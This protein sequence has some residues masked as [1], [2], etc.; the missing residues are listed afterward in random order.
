[1]D[2]KQKNAIFSVVGLANERNELL[3]ALYSVDLAKEHIQLARQTC[4]ASR[5]LDKAAGLIQNYLSVTETRL[6][7]AKK[8]LSIL[9][10]TEDFSDDGEIAFAF[11]TYM[12]AL[13][14]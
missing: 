5:V 12:E 11:N 7:G 10:P 8:V 3:C 13:K 2:Q 6:A 1:M 4:G 14:T 9:F